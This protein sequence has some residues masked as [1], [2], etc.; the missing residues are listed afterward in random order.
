MGIKVPAIYGAYHLF[1][2]VSLS[3]FHRSTFTS[4]DLPSGWKA[5]GMLFLGTELKS[6]IC[7]KELLRLRLAD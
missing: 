5:S 4:S 1:L 2:G 7:R 6:T 3:K